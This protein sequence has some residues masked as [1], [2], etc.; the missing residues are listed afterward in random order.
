LEIAWPRDGTLFAPLYA[1]YKNGAAGEQ[2]RKA[3][4]E[5]LYRKETGSALASA[6]FTHIH[7]E[8][9]HPAPSWVR[10]RWAGWDYIYEKPLPVRVKELEKIFYDEWRKMSFKP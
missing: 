6:H 4:A 2:K 9:I 1:V 3:I 10:Y 5:F 8:V 7:T